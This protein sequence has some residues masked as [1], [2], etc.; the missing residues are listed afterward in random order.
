MALFISVVMGCSGVIMAALYFSGGM[1]I[2]CWLLFFPWSTPGGHESA[3]GGMFS[4]P[5]MCH[6]S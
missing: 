3:S 2:C 1:T 5:G 6:I 4:L